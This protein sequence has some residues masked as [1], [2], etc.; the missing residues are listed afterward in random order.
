MKETGK[1]NMLYLRSKI[2]KFG[3]DQF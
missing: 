1:K 2:Q 3:L